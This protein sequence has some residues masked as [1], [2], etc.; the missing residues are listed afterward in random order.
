MVRW[1][2]IFKVLKRCTVLLLLLS[3]SAGT[4]HAASTLIYFE[5]QGIAG[6][7][8]EL[9]NAV[10]YSMDKGQAMQKPSIGVDF[11]HKFST[12]T[13]DIA[14]LAFQGRVS[15]DAEEK[16]YIEPQVY[17]AYINFKIPYVNLWVGH[18]RTAFGL[19]SYMDSH[20]LLMP[21]LSMMGF[22]FDRDWGV[23]LAA[24]FSIGDAKISAST[25][26]G[27][28]LYFRN[29]YLVSARVSFGI[30][31]QDNFNIGFSGGYGR[32]LETMGFKDMY[33]KPIFFGAGGMD[34]TFLWDN[35]ELRLEAIAG[36]KKIDWVYAFF[37]RFG[38]G[39]LEENR[40]KFEVQPVYLQTETGWDFQ[41]YGGISFYIIPDLALRTMYSYSLDKNDHRA[42]LQIYYYLKII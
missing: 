17:N 38:I 39:V 21:P 4:V 2:L 30:L 18:N 19:A 28:G 25:G 37:A 1:G 33:N 3:G 13:R 6:Y 7:S 15:Y 32:I 14:S 23:G 22:G 9:N 5:A 26:T 34:F 35:F 8:S 20:G 10:F 12:E 41:I 40:L 11:L 42:I 24:D 36:R 16:F 29:N 31:N 27:M